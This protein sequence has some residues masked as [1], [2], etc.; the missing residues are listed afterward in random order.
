M[1]GEHRIL[2]IQNVLLARVIVVFRLQELEG[3]LELR[4]KVPMAWQNEIV[5]QLRGG[6]RVVLASDRIAVM[7]LRLFEG[8]LLARN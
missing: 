6:V 7:D 1:L 2:S 5:V 4:V 3:V 8:Q